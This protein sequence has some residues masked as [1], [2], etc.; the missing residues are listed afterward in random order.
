MSDAEI[1]SAS[2]IGVAPA[3]RSS[4]SRVNLRSAESM[5]VAGGRA[6]RQLRRAS[7]VELGE[8]AADHLER[9]VVIALHREHEAQPVEVGG[10]ELPIP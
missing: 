8:V 4:S 9:Q 10:R 2:S 5:E 1:A 6:T 3:S 7:R